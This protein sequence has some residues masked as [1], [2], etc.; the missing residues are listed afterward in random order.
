MENY[1]AHKHVKV[2]EWVAEHPRLKVRFTS[3]HAS[4]MNHVEVL[5]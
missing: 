5:V 4:W 1:A 3:A 2:R